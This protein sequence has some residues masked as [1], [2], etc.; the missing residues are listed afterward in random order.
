MSQEVCHALKTAL[1]AEKSIQASIPERHGTGVFCK[2]VGLSG[3]LFTWTVLPCVQCLSNPRMT[4][5]WKSWKRRRPLTFELYASITRMC[6]RAHSPAPQA[7]CT[8]AFFSLPCANSFLHSP[9]V[10]F[11]GVVIEDGYAVVRGLTHEQ[12]QFV[13]AVCSFAEC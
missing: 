2:S 4:A 9:T 3:Y 7:S 6:I 5:L 11:R 10:G 8:H 12:S 1:T 13:R